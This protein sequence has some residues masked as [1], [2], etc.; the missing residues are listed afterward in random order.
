[1]CRT[2][3]N[4]RSL[5]DSPSSKGSKAQRNCSS[6][7]APTIKCTGKKVGIDLGDYLVSKG[8][9]VDLDAIPQL[10]GQVSDSFLVGILDG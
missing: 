8:E 3:L 10:K 4:K 1:M 5:K 7:A 9:W 2:G 6:G